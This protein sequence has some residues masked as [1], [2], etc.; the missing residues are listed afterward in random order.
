MIPIVVNCSKTSVL[1]ENVVSSI[2]ITSSPS[3]TVQITGKA[4]T[5][6]LDSTDGG[7]IY[8]S[9]ASAAEVEITSAKCSA[10]NVSLPDKNEKGEE[11]EGL[12]VEKAMPEML[13]TVIR[14]RQLVSNIIEPS[15]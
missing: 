14:N 1:V 10:I 9:A 12:F 5:I 7:Q 11:E 8:L 3:F 4:P 2:S 13:R 15:G 6:Q